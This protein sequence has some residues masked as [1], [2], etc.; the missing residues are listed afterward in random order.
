MRIRQN[1]L[2]DISLFRLY[3]IPHI[4][5]KYPAA[6]VMRSP[7][8]IFRG[9]ADPGTEAFRPLFTGRRPL[10]YWAAING[11]G[12]SPFFIGQHQHKGQEKTADDPVRKVPVRTVIGHRGGQAGTLRLFQGA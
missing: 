8:L 7:V 11:S 12:L 3:L 4:Q 9:C 2:R 6:E 10:F 5:Y 1:A